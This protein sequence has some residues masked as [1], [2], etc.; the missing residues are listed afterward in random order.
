[1]RHLPKF[2]IALAAAVLVIGSLPPPEGHG[3]ADPEDTPLTRPWGPWDD[4]AAF[5]SAD[6][7]CPFLSPSD[8]RR[9][10]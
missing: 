4:C 3:G 5:S 7:R 9:A 1:M 2:L 6:Y 8:A 10:L